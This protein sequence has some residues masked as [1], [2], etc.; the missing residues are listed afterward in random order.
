VRPTPPRMRRAACALAVLAA[1]GGCGD[2]D[3]RGR[4][5]TEAEEDAAPALEGTLTLLALPGYAERG[6]GDPA[7][8]WL[9]GF[10]QRTGCRVQLEVAATPAEALARLASPGIDVAIVPGDLVLTLV[11]SGDIG[12]IE[13][14]R[15]PAL[16]TVAPRLADGPWARQDGVRF[17]VPFVWRPLGLR[18]RVDAF[19]Q[20]PTGAELFVPQVLADRRGNEGRV[21]A[22]DGPMAIADAALHLMRTRPELGIDDPYALDA[23]Q[24]AEAL[25]LVRTQGALVHGWWSDPRVQAQ[26]FAG[27]DVAI[28]TAWPRAARLGD[29]EGATAWTVPAGAIAA[30]ADGGVIAAAAEHP[31]CAYAWLGWSLEP[32]VQDAAAA[33]LGAVP[34]NP[35]A[36]GGPRLGADGCARHGADLVDRAHFRRPAREACGKER[37]CV[38]Y[39]RWTTDFFALR[40]P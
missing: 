3:A 29:D 17:A 8:D 6:D 30:Q 10:E 12:A 21:Q 2:D 23:R 39:S 5:L 18:Y 14:D 37:G 27:G 1:L 36:C 19:K 38:P 28:A 11:A 34:A 16:A 24:Y 13:T 32:Q 7:Y 4:V 33:W 25:A 22:V 40:G 15:V 31:H 20:P 35:A 9:T 26:D